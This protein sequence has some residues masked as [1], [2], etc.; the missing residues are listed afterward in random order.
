MLKLGQDVLHPHAMDSRLRIAVEQCG[1]PVVEY[2]LASFREACE[3]CLSNKGALLAV[4]MDCFFKPIQAV[5]RCSDYWEFPICSMETR[6]PLLTTLSEVSEYAGPTYLEHDNEKGSPAARFMEYMI[7]TCIDAATQ[8]DHGIRRMPINIVL[9]RIHRMLEESRWNSNIAKVIGCTDEAI[10]DVADRIMLWNG[11]DLRACSRTLE[12]RIDTWLKSTSAA[13]VVEFLGTAV[14]Q[15][16]IGDIAAE[17]ARLLPSASATLTRRRELDADKAA[18]YSVADFKN[19]CTFLTSTHVKSV[20]SYPT[21]LL[22]TSTP[23]G[24][25]G[26]LINS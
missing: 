15:N 12:N 1:L 17:L 8:N 26:T 2:T 18:F 4:D 3:L 13:I 25:T 10:V 6:S 11:A 23:S 20:W 21:T 7:D 5:D 24:P 19:L 22:G 14:S 16:T 9:S